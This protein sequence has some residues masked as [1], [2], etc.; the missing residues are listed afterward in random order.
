MNRIVGVTEEYWGALDEDNRF[1]WKLFNRAITFAGA[2]IVTKT[3]LNYVD[4]VLA[5]VATLLPM[6]LIESQRSYRR[7]SS[8]LRKQIVRVFILLGTWCLVVL[9]MA[10]FIQVGLISIVSVFISMVG[11]SRFVA[12]NKISPIV[13]VLIF[14]V[15]GV[16]AMVRVF[17]EL[18]FWELIYH[19]PRQQLKKL[20]V[21]K[22]F[23]ADCFALFAWFEI[24]VI[25]V[26]FLYV[27]TAVEIFKLFVIMF[28]TIVWR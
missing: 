8:W 28:D 11:S 4:W 23:K 21:Y 16:V 22:V 3:G 26:G 2:L 25:L 18:G 17:K 9:G 5:A 15:C 14:A 27:N 1:K 6:L 20:L 12:D 13:L 7:F 19:L 10:Y 24:M